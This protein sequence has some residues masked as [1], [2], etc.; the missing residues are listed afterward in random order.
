MELETYDSKRGSFPDVPGSHWAA[1]YIQE[2]TRNGWIVGYADGLFHGGDQ[3]TRAEVAAIVNG[4]W[5]ARRTSGLSG[6][7]RTS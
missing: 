6:T 2:A 5:A 4:C 3:I 1:D 7:M